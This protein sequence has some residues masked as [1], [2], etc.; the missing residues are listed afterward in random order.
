MW[1]EKKRGPARPQEIHIR[2]WMDHLTSQRQPRCYVSSPLWQHCKKGR[3]HDQT[4]IQRM[5]KYGFREV[6][7]YVQYVC[8]LCRRQ[9]CLSLPSQNLWQKRTLL[10]VRDMSPIGERHVIGCWSKLVI[11]MYN[12]VR[13]DPSEGP[14]LWGAVTLKVE[15]VLCTRTSSFLSW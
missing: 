7:V 9:S 5:R 15:I 10:I 6:Y 11:H 2:L 3:S 8:S 4:K 1:G 14:N 13:T 12:K